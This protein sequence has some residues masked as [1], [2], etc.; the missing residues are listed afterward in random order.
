MAVNFEKLIDK[1]ITSKTDVFLTQDGEVHDRSKYLNASEAWSCLRRLGYEKQGVPADKKYVQ[2]WGYFERGNTVEEWLVDVLHKSLPK[3]VKLLY[4]G[5]KQRTLR[6]GKVS[7]TPDGL[8]I[9]NG[10]TETVLEM[11]SI[12]PRANL[13]DGPRHSHVLQCKVQIELF[14]QTTKHAPKKGT[15]LYVDASNYHTLMAFPVKRDKDVLTKMENRAEQAFTQKP[16]DLPAE[17][18]WTDECRL[19]PFAKRCKNATVK[20]IPHY[21]VPDAPKELADELQPWLEQ[22]AVAAAA[23][24]G[25]GKSKAEAD[26]HIKSILT[27]HSISKTATPDWRI[28]YVVSKGRES[29]DTDAMKKDKID[30]AK[31][32]KR[33]DDYGRLTVTRTKPKGK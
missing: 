17:G 32:M 21:A 11:K 9:E 33:G 27:Q 2:E 4:A 31:Y 12:D 5:E 24:E 6:K 1:H 8:L 18:A 19:C 20:A 10:K 15:I 26:E 29:L 16:D 23:Y 22:R 13:N 28:N 25:A 7:A 14:N 30:V 3:T